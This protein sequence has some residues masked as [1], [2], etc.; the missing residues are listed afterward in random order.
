L[1]AKCCKPVPG[2]DIIGFISRGKG[3]VVHRATC[4]NLKSVEQYRLIEA[5]WNNNQSKGFVANVQIEAQNSDSLLLKI[6]TI[7][8][9]NKL[10][11]RHINL[12]QH[13]DQAIVLFGVVVD[14]VGQVNTLINKLDTLKEA[15]LVYRV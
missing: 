7:I 10:T 12:R 13:K 4:N 3:I 11:L 2:D 9:E 6:S 8:S 14:D 15:N 1:V 5:E